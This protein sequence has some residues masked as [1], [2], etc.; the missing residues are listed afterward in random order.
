MTTSEHAVSQKYKQGNDTTELYQ[1][2]K[3]STTQKVSAHEFKLF[4]LEYCFVKPESYNVIITVINENLWPGLATYGCTMTYIK[5]Y[6]KCGVLTPYKDISGLPV[7]V[8]QIN[9][10]E[11]ADYGPIQVLV[12]GEGQY[13]QT[14]NFT[15]A[16]RFLQ[17]P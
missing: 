10:N 1:V 3:T 15:I 8:V 2:F 6:G 4:Q 13:N 5:Q 7:N 16:A 11:P 9:I 17:L 14:N 12:L